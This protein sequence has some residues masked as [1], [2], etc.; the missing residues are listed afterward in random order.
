MAVKLQEKY[1][2]SHKEKRL[3]DKTFV[4]ML[5]QGEDENGQPNYAYLGIKATVLE[6]V[7][8]KLNRGKVN[9]ASFGKVFRQGKGAEPTEEDKQ[10][11]EDTYFF[12]H[13]KINVGVLN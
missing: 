10:Y 12:N 4:L 1:E 5:I 13:D 2:F 11:M 6:E 9:L 3:A 7:S 8:Q